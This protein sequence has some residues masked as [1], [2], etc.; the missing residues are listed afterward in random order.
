MT[1]IQIAASD[2]STTESDTVLMISI[3]SPGIEDEKAKLSWSSGYALLEI[4]IL[5]I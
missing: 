2:S 5:R 4:D 3:F 1:T